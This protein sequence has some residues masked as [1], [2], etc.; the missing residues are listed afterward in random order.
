MHQDFRVASVAQLEEQRGRAQELG[1][2]LL[3]DG[4]G[5]ESEPLYALADPAGHP[6]CILVSAG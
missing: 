5:D 1:A 6:F 4:S 2:V 3:H